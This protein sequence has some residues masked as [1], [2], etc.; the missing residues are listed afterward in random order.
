MAVEI[1]DTQRKRV[2]KVERLRTY[3]KADAREI[4]EWS[5]SDETLDFK[6]MSDADVRAYL[7]GSAT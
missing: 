7:D 6:G 4:D 2:E 5:P 3:F 1:S